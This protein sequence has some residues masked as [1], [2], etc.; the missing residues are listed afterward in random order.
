M[1]I[2]TNQVYF[3]DLRRISVEILRTSRRWL[4]I[5]VAWI[6]FEFYNEIFFELVKKGVKI[7]IIVNDDIINRKALHLIN[8]LCAN[9]ISVYLVKMPGRGYMHHK[10][11]VIDERY[12]VIGSYNWTKNATYNS[13]EDLTYIDNVPIAYK[14]LQEFETLISYSP[15]ELRQLLH[16]PRCSRCGAPIYTLIQIDDEN[17]FESRVDYWNACDCGIIHMDSRF[18][19]KGLIIAYDEAK[20]FYED[21]IES[22]EM[23]GEIVEVN[24]WNALADYKRSRL[25]RA[26]RN[27]IPIFHGII[28][29]HY[30]WISKNDCI[31]YYEMVWKEKGTEANIKDYY[32]ISEISYY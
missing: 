28:E 5:A 3:D 24:Y 29:K 30:K 18:M 12:A 23:Q 21:E 8:D 14:L 25:M 22:A 9:G 1:A 31:A 11:C 17:E 2:L 27:S 7:S 10:Y 13:A 4:C 32:D 16:P 15:E 20:H 26:I 6:D 19:E